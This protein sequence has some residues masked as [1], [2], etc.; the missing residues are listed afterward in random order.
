M[1]I[2]CVERVCREVMLRQCVERVCLE[3]VCQSVC[4]SL[5]LSF[6]RFYR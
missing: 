3:G 1:S 4:L 6:P 5:S 2:G